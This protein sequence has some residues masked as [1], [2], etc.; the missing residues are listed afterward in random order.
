MLPTESTYNW[1]MADSCLNCTLRA[2]HFFCGL[3]AVGLQSLAAISYP[4][5]YPERAVLFVQ[6][7]CNGF[8]A[9]LSPK[10]RLPSPQIRFLPDGSQCDTW[11]FPDMFLNLARSLPIGSQVPVISALLQVQ[12]FRALMQF[13]C[14]GIGTRSV[15]ARSHHDNRVS[16]VGAA[17]AEFLHLEVKGGALHSKPGSRSRRTADHSG[18]F[19]KYAQYLIA[20]CALQPVEVCVVP[21]V[22]D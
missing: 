10:A 16:Q 17:D 19:A 20:F 9:L 22:A 14:S 1:E 18:S 6:G 7:Q 5:I 2:D 15:T 21:V 13:C 11:N 4:S 12:C 3:S 8:P